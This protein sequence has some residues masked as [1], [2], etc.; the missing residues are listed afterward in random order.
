MLQLVAGAKQHYHGLTL[1]PFAIQ[2]TV[3]LYNVMYGI[4]ACMARLYERKALCSLAAESLSGSVA[5][6]RTTFNVPS[7]VI[8][9]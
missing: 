6:V 7:M 8:F 2:C 3:Y 4:I 5:V 1:L 9:Y